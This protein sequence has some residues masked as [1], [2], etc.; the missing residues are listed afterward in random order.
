MKL[1]VWI[2]D[3]LGVPLDMPDDTTL[4]KLHD[5][6]LWALVGLWDHFYVYKGHRYEV[7]LKPFPQHLPL[8][9]FKKSLHPQENS[10]RTHALLL[11]PLFFLKNPALL[12][13]CV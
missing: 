7:C 4:D 5:K 11:S 8:P 6:M 12:L 1:T 13:F 10:T 3:N 2:T 9:P